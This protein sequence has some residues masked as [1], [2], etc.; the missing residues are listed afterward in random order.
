[1]HIDDEQVEL[2][3]VVVVEHFRTDGSPGSASE[4]F[5]GHVGEL[6]VAQVAVEL[7]SAKHVGDEQIDEPVFIVVERRDIAPPACPFEPGLCGHIG[8]RAV[9]VVV[10][11]H[12]MFFRARCQ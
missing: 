11:Q 8:K 7:A 3:V 12:V 10:I 5:V 6:S 9:A 2:A 4:R 1:M